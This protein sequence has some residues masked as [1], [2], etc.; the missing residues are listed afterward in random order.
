MIQNFVKRVL[1]RTILRPEF[2]KFL[3]RARKSRDTYELALLYVNCQLVA[4]TAEERLKQKW[5]F[6]GI[7]NSQIFQSHVATTEGAV[8]SVATTLANALRN[9]GRK[10]GKSTINR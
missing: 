1:R 5:G 8:K 4:R 2:A 6:E 7:D 10:E 3:K 9:S